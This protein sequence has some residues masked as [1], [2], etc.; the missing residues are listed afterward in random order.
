MDVMAIQARDQ[1]DQRD[2][3]PLT[4]AVWALDLMTSSAAETEQVR[5]VPLLQAAAGPSYPILLRE[6]LRKVHCGKEK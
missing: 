3:N 4:P 1:R 6:I 2:T 5:D